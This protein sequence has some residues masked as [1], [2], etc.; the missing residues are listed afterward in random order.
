MG[1]GKTLEDAARGLT[2]PDRRREAVAKTGRLALIHKREP[3]L[4]C[5]LQFHYVCNLTLAD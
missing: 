2:I 4:H 3:Q 5:C 1:H